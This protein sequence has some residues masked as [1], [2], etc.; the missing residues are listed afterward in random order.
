MRTAQDITGL[1]KVIKG[2]RDG[3]WL[4]MPP[5]VMFLLSTAIVQF[6]IHPGWSS[7]DLA[8][9]FAEA[10][11]ALGRHLSHRL[12]YASMAFFHIALCL[13]VMLFFWRQLRDQHQSLRR[14]AYRFM[15]VEAFLFL[16]VWLVWPDPDVTLFKL[17]YQ[18]VNDLLAQTSVG[19]DLTVGRVSKLSLL[20]NVPQVFGIFSIVLAVGVVGSLARGIPQNSESEWRAHFATRV[21]SLQKCF[22]G[23]SAVLVTS[24]LTVSLF[25]HFPAELAADADTRAALNL[26]AQGLTIF[27]GTV[28]T[29]TLLVGKPVLAREHRARAFSWDPIRGSH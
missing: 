26:Y 13:S 24:T 27:W 7:E 28:Y 6:V 16:A 21:R 18:N 12:V 17:S 2:L 5:A 19:S 22:L 20:A 10:P 29:L 4:I 1:D 25:F 11:G 8:P 3:L 14:R 23:L 15:A 9:A